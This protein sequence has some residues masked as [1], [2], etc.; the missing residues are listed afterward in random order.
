MSDQ[1]KPK[2]T[3][4]KMVVI[5]VVIVV[6]ILIGASVSYVLTRPSS[7]APKKSISQAQET[8]SLTWAD[9]PTIDP[10][11]GNDEASDSAIVNLYDALVTPTPN[12]GVTPDLATSWTVSSNGLVYTFN[13]RPDVTFHNGD[14]LTANDV[15]FSMNRIITMGEGNSYL[16]SPYVANTSAPNNSTVV[17]TLK[18][19]FAPFLDSLVYLYVLDQK[20]VMAHIASGSYGAYGDYGDKWLLT[21]DAG[22]G[23]YEVQSVNLESN[24]T[25]AEY[26]NY[27]NGTLPNQPKYVN[28]IGSDTASTV[29]ALFSSK[30]IQ[31]TDQWQTYST[32]SSLS[33]LAGAKMTTIHDAE[34]MFLMMNTQSAPTNSIYIREAMY[35]LLNYTAVISQIFPGQGL[36]QGI[37]PSN[38]P[39]ADTSLPSTQQNLAKAK[40]LIQES[41][42]A[43]NIS[44]YPVVYLETTAVPAEAQLAALFESDASQ[45]G[46]TVNVEGVPWL[47]M[48]ADMSNVSSA[49]NICSVE[50][51][52]SYFEAGSYL[53]EM[54]TT[55]A[56]GTYYQNFWLNNTTLDSTIANSVT[57]QNQSARFQAY[58]SIQDMLYNQYIV[59]P[60]FQIT[61]VR[62]Y[63]PNIVNWYAADGQNI[64][65]LGYD[66]MFRDIGFNVSAM[67]S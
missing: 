58:Y 32:I 52:P 63:Y 49:P 62:A 31:I 55:Q 25:I 15:V 39:G 26:A 65:L 17:I 37:M 28:F 40:Q 12:G 10:A 38:I 57:I 21:H 67:P 44:K 5:I 64:P 6:V 16:F 11:V 14:I 56:Q 29:Q 51:A 36:G 19:P 9:V 41:P 22:T 60:A 27:W 8:L 53:Q 3:S 20:Q 23:P 59:I 43:T 48:E 33:T 2:A 18:T 7:T 24:I 1:T 54:Y 46:I 34:D 66:F 35:Y 50:V 45:V 4:R 13:I 61:E 30:E 47:T 42:Y